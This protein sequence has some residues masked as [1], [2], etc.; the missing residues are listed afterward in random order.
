LFVD[1]GNAGAVGY[2]HDNDQDTT[3]KNALATAW[4]V[5]F[6]VKGVF[7]AVVFDYGTTQYIGD[8]GSQRRLR[9]E[10]FEKQMELVITKA[11]GT[12]LSKNS[13]QYPYLFQDWLLANN[14]PEHEALKKH[15]EPFIFAAIEKQKQ[16]LQKGLLDAYLALRRGGV[17]ILPVDGSIDGIDLVSLLSI[18]AEDLDR[19]DIA[20]M[21]ST[22]EESPVLPQLTR[23]MGTSY[24]DFYSITKK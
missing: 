9:S 15:Y 18:S 14:P 12:K 2:L 11:D 4:P 19:R 22:F 3:Q 6:P 16:I 1:P 8:D 5:D 24:G 13:F 10:Y 23:G 21:S 20:S 17:L 7:D